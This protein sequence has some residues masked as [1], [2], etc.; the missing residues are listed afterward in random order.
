MLCLFLGLCRCPH[1]RRQFLLSPA[2]VISRDVEI[3]LGPWTDHTVQRLGPAATS[4]GEGVPTVV[5]SFTLRSVSTSSVPMGSDVPVVPLSVPLGCPTPSSSVTSSGQS[6][7]PSSQTLVWG[8][9]GDSLVPLFPIVSR[10]DALRMIRKR[11]VSSMYH[12]FRRDF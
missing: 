5:L 6:T 1:N 2:T 12:R 7:T 3:H 10:Q 8:D 11:V 9:T 4:V